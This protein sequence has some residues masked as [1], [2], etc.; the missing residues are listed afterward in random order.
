MNVAEQMA[1]VRRVLDWYDTTPHRWQDL[2]ACKGLDT[3]AFY[4]P[5]PG[6]EG[7]AQSEYRAGQARAAEAK[8]TCQGCPVSEE[9][10][11]AG[12]YEPGIWGGQTDRERNRVSNFVDLT[13]YSRVLHR[14]QTV[15]GRTG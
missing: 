14:R 7:I 4:P 13:E 9:C 3:A 12:M 15:A 6:E 8:A 1:E 10:T 5:T 2:A 11:E